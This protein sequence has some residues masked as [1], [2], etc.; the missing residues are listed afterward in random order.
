MDWAGWNGALACVVRLSSPVQEEVVVFAHSRGSLG[1]EHVSVAEG[2]P[3]QM[4]LT[5]S[6]AA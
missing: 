4:H 5:P 2:A 1:V 6:V 3:E